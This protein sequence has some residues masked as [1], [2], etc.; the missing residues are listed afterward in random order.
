MAELAELRDQTQA[1]MV[2]LRADSETHAPLRGLTPLGRQRWAAVGDTA[3]ALRVSIHER[4]LAE[5][6]ARAAEP[7]RRW[8]VRRPACVDSSKVNQSVRPKPGGHGDFS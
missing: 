2:A 3:L 1:H 7:R 5:E 6:D 4:M 8:R